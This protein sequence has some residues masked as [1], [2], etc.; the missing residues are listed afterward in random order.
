MEGA[1]AEWL[2]GVALHIPNFLVL[3]G[4]AS[5]GELTHSILTAKMNA[6]QYSG[7]WLKTPGPF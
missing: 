6:C 2:V 5:A 7:H 1:E 4:P 3:R